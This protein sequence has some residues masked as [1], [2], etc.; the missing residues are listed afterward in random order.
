MASRL[1][2]HLLRLMTTNRTV[3][4]ATTTVLGRRRRFRSTPATTRPINFGAKHG[5]RP[6]PSANVSR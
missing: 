6:R 4:H 3:P 2:A 1:I 5:G